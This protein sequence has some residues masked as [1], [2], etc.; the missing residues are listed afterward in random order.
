MSNQQ[1]SL[2]PLQLQIGGQALFTEQ[3]IRLLEAIGEY[4]SLS[5]AAKSLPMSYKA[6]WDAL[7]T[8]NN[9]SE[10]PL[11]ITQS[12][13]RRGGGTQLTVAAT[14]LIQV[15]RALQLEYQQSLVKLQPLLANQPEFE[16]AKLRLL[17]R[18]L[19]FQSSARN[20]IS[21]R[22]IKVNKQGVRAQVVVQAGANFQVKA[23]VTSEAVHELMLAPGVEV[24]ALIKAPQVKLYA[25]EHRVH[26]HANYYQGSITRLSPDSH[27][28]Q[29]SVA[30]DAHK[31]LAA[32]LKTKQVE[33]LALVEGQMIAVGFSPSAVVLCRYD[34]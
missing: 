31:N 7:D 10:Q 34:A 22:V 33:Q 29:V 14:Q 19:H 30:I 16:L 5:A 21:G 2:L 4:G 18:Q 3:R 24:L 28:C 25:P 27:H 20:Q 11:V 26:S 12:G 1:P 32:L 17:L 8:M 23:A 15:Y 9:L 13:G 6:A